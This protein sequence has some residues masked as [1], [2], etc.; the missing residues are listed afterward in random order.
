[1]NLFISFF[2]FRSANEDG[3][4]GG[5]L[6]EDVPREKINVAALRNVFFHSGNT[7]NEKRLPIIKEPS[8][9]SSATAIH[10]LIPQE[11]N[12]DTPPHHGVVIDQAEEATEVKIQC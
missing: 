11:A 10:I 3:D 7:C 5:N 4:V 8:P 6:T 12:D 9:I 1:M 2:Q